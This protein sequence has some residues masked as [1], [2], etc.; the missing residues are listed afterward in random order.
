MATAT[1]ATAL[2]LSF[3]FFDWVLLVSWLASLPDDGLLFM[4]ETTPTD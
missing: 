4:H 2:L 3:G 1:Y